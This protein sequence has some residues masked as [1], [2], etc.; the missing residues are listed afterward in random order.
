MKR[1]L[2]SSEH[3]DISEKYITPTDVKQFVFCPRVTYF[4]KVMRLK[5]I[6]GSQ[7]EAGKKSHDKLS[8]LEKRRQ[9]LL[10]A[11]LPISIEH[12][13]FDVS[14]VSNKLEAMG[15][16]DMLVQTSA[17]EY[18]PVE[19][20]DMFSNRGKL[21]LDHKY[22]LVVLALLVEDTF[23]VI[24]QRGIVHYMRDEITVNTRISVG[25]KNRAKTYIKRIKQMIHS[26]KIPNSR[27]QC[28]FQHVGCGYADQCTDFQ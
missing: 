24:V 17:K 11:K 8:R 20:K 9:S 6:M 19:F 18:I 28:R 7:Q 5:P 25:M 27:R 2:W 22:Q 14:L 3:T 13:Q 10:K 21:H 12:K 1:K 23:N 16:L 4:T 26:G 15:R